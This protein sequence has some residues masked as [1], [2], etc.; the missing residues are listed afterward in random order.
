MRLGILGGRLIWDYRGNSNDTTLWW[1]M[2]SNFDANACM[3]LLIMSSWRNAD[4][5]S[6]SE[7]V[8]ALFGP[9]GSLVVVVRSWHCRVIV[10]VISMCRVRCC[11]CYCYHPCHSV[12][13]WYS[14]C[15]GCWHLTV[16]VMMWMAMMFWWWCNG[17]DTCNTFWVCSW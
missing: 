3:I 12:V 15:C 11:C 7:A 8:K 14:L 1:Q 5:R 10:A 6:L 17:T 16:V 4:E 2:M 13:I 9:A